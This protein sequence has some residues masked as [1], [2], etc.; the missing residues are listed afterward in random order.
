MIDQEKFNSLD[1]KTRNELMAELTNSTIRQVA[2]KTEL[3]VKVKGFE[4]LY[5]VSNWGKVYS[6]KSKKEL[7]MEPHGP[8]GSVQVCLRKE[9]KETM[10][11]VHRLVADHFLCNPDPEKYT[12][13]LHYDEDCSNNRVDNLYFGTLKDACNQSKVRENARET[14][15]RNHGTIVGINGT[16]KIEARSQ[17]EAAE[18]TGVSKSGVN[19]AIKHG[20]SPK[21]WRFSI[22]CQSET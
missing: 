18:M 21:G 19:Y 16:E 13:V 3:W 17:R 8:K 22:E 2:K 11:L 5:E 9:G 12:C 1:T 14:N 20:T 6:I 7:S 15:R 4:E 10:Y